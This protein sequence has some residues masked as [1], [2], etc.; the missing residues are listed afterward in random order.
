MTMDVHAAAKARLEGVEQRYTSGRREL[1]DVLADAGRPL[2]VAEIVERRRGLAQSSAYRNLGVLEQ[3]GVVRRVPG[4]DE[5]VRYE[6]DEELTEHH[7][8]LVCL[9]CG[10]VTDYTMS[11]QLERSVKKAIDAITSDTGFAP[12][13]HQLDLFGLCADCK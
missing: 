4:A 3:A 13:A 7:H 6:L 5:F 8:H 1:V 2:V 10:K 9:N 11:D 12:T